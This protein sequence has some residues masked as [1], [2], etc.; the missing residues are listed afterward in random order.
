MALSLLRPRIPSS[1]HGQLAQLVSRLDRPC[2]HA[3]AL[4]LEDKSYS[5]IVFPY[6]KLNKQLNM[7]QSHYTLSFCRFNH[8][9]TG[10]N[11]HFSCQPPEDFAEILSWLRKISTEKVIPPFF[12]KCQFSMI[13]HHF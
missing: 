9:K 7:M 11:V 4:G 6:L 2:L 5:K 1:H 13:I 3:V 12:L 10:K 8:P